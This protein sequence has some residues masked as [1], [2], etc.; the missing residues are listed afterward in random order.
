MEINN[1]S[2]LV[3]AGTTGILAINVRS[4]STMNNINITVNYTI[5]P[6]KDEHQE[7]INS[8]TFYYD[9]QNKTVASMTYMQLSH[10]Q[11]L[12]S[13]SCAHPLQYAITLLLFQ[14]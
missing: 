4:S 13:G 7:Q 6:T 2:V 10:F 9:S 12:T 1:I 14:L 8:I 5:C 11:L 3:T